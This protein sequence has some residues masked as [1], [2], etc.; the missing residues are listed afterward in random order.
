MIHWTLDAVMQA[1]LMSR[2]ELVALEVLCRRVGS[3][4]KPSPVEAHHVVAARKG[5]I[6]KGR[7]VARSPRKLYLSLW[8]NFETLQ[9]K[10]G[11]CCE[12]PIHTGCRGG[13]EVKAKIAEGW[14][15]ITSKAVGKK[16]TPPYQKHCLSDNKL[17]PECDDTACV[18]VHV[19]VHVCVYNHWVPAWKSN[20]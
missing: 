5:M 8:N 15:W 10:N 18:C 4:Q 19:H 12:E 1:W 7:I 2:M 20:L 9:N 13:L 11:T 17:I 16:A 3:T 14:P 6:S